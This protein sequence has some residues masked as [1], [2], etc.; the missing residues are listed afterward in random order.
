MPGPMPFYFILA[1]PF[2]FVHELGYFSL[3]G[4]ILFVIIIK[5][6]KIERG[7]LFVGV[8]MVV[9]SAFYLS[10]TIS[11]SNIFLNSSL[12]LFSVL[13][14]S[15]SLNMRKKYHILLN[16]V[17]IGLFLSTRNVFVIPYIVLFLHS[18]KS[19]IYNLTDTI[20]IG[21]VVLLIF[22]T[23]FIP[24]VINHFQSFKEMNP[25]IIQSS[26]LMPQS[27]SL[28]CVLFTLTSFFITKSFKDVLFFSGLYLFI[29]ILVY[30][31][32]QV[33]ILGFHQAIFQSKVDLS[34]FILCVP[35]FLYYILSDKPK[36]DK[37]EDKQLII[38]GIK[39]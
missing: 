21:I 16:G 5:Y 25:F 26:F 18:L 13:F 11:R 29:T 2:Y 32:Y 12:V 38:N 34:Y 37:L 14:F 27:L 1:L 28:T 35:F 30:V 4:L 22:A 15:N 9:G 33:Y 19:K 17:I 31:L 20:K 10:E 8:L 3:F 24:F 6:Y 36:F 23:T 7:N 39:K